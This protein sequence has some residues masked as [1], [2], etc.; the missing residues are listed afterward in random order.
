MM[1][2]CSEP[3]SSASHCCC[4]TDIDIAVELV[5]TDIE[6]GSITGTHLQTAIWS[7][8]SRE[9]ISSQKP[10]E[11]FHFPLLEPARLLDP[12]HHQ[13]D[14]SEMTEPQE[15]ILKMVLL[16]EQLG[17]LATTFSS[18]GLATLR[19]L[20]LLSSLPRCWVDCFNKALEQ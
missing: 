8:S 3:L 14:Q 1:S 15:L 10:P 18:Q 13:V 2:P 20:C 7:A 12:H 16:V 9:G 5:S 11:H 4:C 17:L 6:L 19:V